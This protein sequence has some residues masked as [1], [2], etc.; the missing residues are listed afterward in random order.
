MSSN[1]HS[2]DN[3]EKKLNDS[4]LTKRAWIIL[5]STSCKK[6]KKLL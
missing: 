4:D 5:F 1:S 2:T 6:E 3:V